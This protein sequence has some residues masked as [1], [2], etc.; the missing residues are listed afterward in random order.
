MKKNKFIVLLVI[1]LLVILSSSVMAA[2]REEF[3]SAINSFS[4]GMTKYSDRFMYTEDSNEEKVYS[5]YTN[6]TIYVADKNN[7]MLYFSDDTFCMYIYHEVLGLDMS[8]DGKVYEQKDVYN[9]IKNKKDAKFNYFDDISNGDWYIARDWDKYK[10]ELKPGD[11]LIEKKFASYGY[12]GMYVGNGKILMFKESGLQTY[13]LNEATDRAL[14]EGFGF[15]VARIKEEEIQKV[16]SL[17][18][19]FD[20][21]IVNTSA[22]TMA[23]AISNLGLTVK[24][25]NGNFVFNKTQKEI[26]TAIRTG[27]LSEYGDIKNLGGICFQLEYKDSSGNMRIVGDVVSDKLSGEIANNSTKTVNSVSISASTSRFDKLNLSDFASVGYLYWGTDYIAQEDHSLY[28]G[29]YIYNKLKDDYEIVVSNIPVSNGVE[30]NKEISCFEQI[31]N[32]NSKLSDYLGVEIEIPDETYNLQF[33]NVGDT[34]V[35]TKENGGYK[36]NTLNE[37][38]FTVNKSGTYAVKIKTNTKTIDNV[39]VYLARYDVGNDDIVGHGYFAQQRIR[40][41]GVKTEGICEDSS[42]ENKKYNNGEYLSGYE[43]TAFPFIKEKIYVLNTAQTIGYS[44]DDC[45]FEITYISDA[46]VE[47]RDHESERENIYTALESQSSFGVEELHMGGEKGPT[48]FVR[49]EYLMSF[50][51]RNIANGIVITMDAALG[52][53]DENDTNNTVSIDTIIFDNYPLTKLNLFTKSLK[54]GEEQNSFIATF[55]QNINKWFSNFTLIAVVAYLII[56]L[57]MGIRI[58][59][60]STAAKKSIYKELF[61]Q[62]VTGIILLFI[63]PVVIRYA[64]EINSAFVSMVGE[65]IQNMDN[66]NVNIEYKDPNEKSDLS[67]DEVVTEESKNMEL[68][69]FAENDKGYM[70]VMA[71][72]AHTTRRLSYAFIYLIMAFQLVI[73]AVMYYKR[74]FMVAFLLVIFPVIMVAHVLEKV[75][76]VRTGGAFSKWTK[77]IL[78]TIFVQSIHAVIYS[79]TSATVIAAGDTNND[80]ILMIVGVSFL[81]NGESILKKILGYDSQTTPSLAQTAVKTAAAVTFTK[82]A[83]TSV[84]DNVVGAGSHLQTAIQYGREAKKLDLK[85]RLVNTIGEKPKQYKMPSANELKHYKSEYDEFGDT[86]AKEI[87]TSIQVLNHLDLASPEQITKA[88]QTIE[89]AKGE[90]KYNNLLKD[91]KMDDKTFKALQNARNTAAYDAVS[92]H[93]TKQQIDMELTMELERI[94]PKQDIR[95]V[96]LSMYSQMAK[97]MNNTS[98]TAR[99]TEE[100]KVKAEIQKARDRYNR[101]SGKIVIADKSN[102]ESGDKDLEERAAK[103]LTSIYGKDEKFTNDQYKMALSACILKDSK[104]GK[105]DANELM[106]AANYAFKNQFKDDKFER[107]A[108]YVGED[109]GEF[110]Y[111]IAEAVCKKG[112]GESSTKDRE[113]R[114][115]ENKNMAPKKEELTKVCKIAR[116]VIDETEE[117]MTSREEEIRETGS[118]DSKSEKKRQEKEISELSD[119]ISIVDVKKMEQEQERLGVTE[120]VQVKEIIRKRQKKN[121]REKSILMDFS[122]QMVSENNDIYKNKIDGM[123]KDELREAKNIAVR[124]KNKEIGRT[125]QTTTATVVGAPIGAG[126]T[127]G[128]SDSDDTLKEGLA[129]ALAGAAAFDKVAEAAYDETTHKRKVKM[130]NPYTGEMETVEVVVAGSFSDAEL[131]T[132]LSSEG[133]SKMSAKLKE[134]FLQNKVN[135]DMKWDAEKTAKIQKEE[136]KKRLDEAYKKAIEETAKKRN[137]SNKS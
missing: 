90:G 73:I 134:Q 120:E 100:S 108:S 88:M 47:I 51:V 136:Y 3:E 102:I 124:K 54:P 72:R 8:K 22:M 30:Q 2:T 12:C 70:A 122:A 28:V 53:V 1:T 87:G 123:T 21:S 19:N 135:R 89:K 18:T 118:L 96:K 117:V 64:I 35:I 80:W 58:V 13:D 78:I 66:S 4:N 113:W 93:K 110:R 48:L 98:L 15:D 23:D 81:F 106:T 69:P 42:C 83:V 14:L 109:L 25:E 65:T 92:K 77:E 115:K 37:I 101:L 49:L 9:D 40:H 111:A 34:Q 97:P 79:F 127:I 132:I 121:T 116:D 84:A 85:S 36:K 44:T 57:Y 27:F 86:E 7:T 105:Y 10:K 5:G 75:A 60:N 104:S 61:V 133:A 39:T 99:N 74:L 38:L 94:L 41:A 45:T 16:T 107:M 55:A 56:L 125:L 6:Q 33:G 46:L 62:W 91:L 43:K 119:I 50:C 68:Y 71:K 130:R 95:A 129:G 82:K 20:A 63:F 17:K 67:T 131:T 32:D 114:Y 26:A 112:Y 76:N 126:V 59:M 31:T 128:L 29:I 24:I 103:L 52:W 137:D 11:M